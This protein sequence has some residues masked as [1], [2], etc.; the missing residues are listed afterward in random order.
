MAATTSRP[1]I[2]TLGSTPEFPSTTA[3]QESLQ[4]LLSEFE[5]LGISQ[6]IDYHSPQVTTTHEG[7]ETVIYNPTQDLHSAINDL[8]DI[9]QYIQHHES[10]HHFHYNTPF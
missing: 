1:S 8:S 7:V 9:F 3:Q 10:L 6:N 2:N 5:N 4:E